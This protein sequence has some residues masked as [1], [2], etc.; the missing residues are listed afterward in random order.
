[1]DEPLISLV[2]GNWFELKPYLI[3]A[4]QPYTLDMLR[5]EIYTQ[6]ASH[7][8]KLDFIAVKYPKKYAK[9]VMEDIII[10]MDEVKFKQAIELIPNE[11]YH[12]MITFH[13]TTSVDIMDNI[14]KVGYVLPG[15]IDPTSGKRIAASHG[16]AYGSGVYTSPHFDKALYYT[17][18]TATHAYMLVNLV[19]PGLVK[20]IDPKTLLTGSDGGKFTR[21]VYGLDQ[22]I[23]FESKRVIP[24]GVA[25]IK[26]A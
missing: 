20:M 21:I 17:H 6:V 5:G 26:I 8:K 24:V 9:P 13:G 18:P 10:T 7:E 12:P 14:N 23:S 19:F 15:E 2:P 11:K 4:S 16:A 25:H 22:I 3:N 1:M